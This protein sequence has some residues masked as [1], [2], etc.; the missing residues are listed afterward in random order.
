MR[1]QERVSS[2]RS[3][4]WIDEDPA[5]RQHLRSGE[6]VVLPLG[7]SSPTPVPHGLIHH[8]IG[9]VFIPGAQREDLIAVMNDYSRYDKIYRPT[10]IKAEPLDSA[11][12]EKRFSLQWVQ[13]VLFATVALD[14]Q[15]VSTSI[16]L[17]R[18]QGYMTISSTSVQQI[19]HYG[20]KDE[21]KLQPDEGSGYL[22]R[23][24][25]FARF[26][27]RDGGLYLELEVFGLSRDLPTSLRLLLKPVIDHV[28]RQALSV[29]LE[30][31]REAVRSQA[32]KRVSALQVTAP[33]N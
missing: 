23:V 5:R 28:P 12:D 21:R 3:F 4:L 20:Q 1:M 10:V 11:G 19:E 24:A 30:Q 22:W 25:S 16:D 33:E 26:E 8:W 6:V 15:F 13:R 17:N 14:V 32:A 27:E 2:T 31:T 29:K 18:R 9:G 7:K